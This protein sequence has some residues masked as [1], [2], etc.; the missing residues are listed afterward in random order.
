ML[1]FKVFRYQDYIHFIFPST[2]NRIEGMITY[3]NHL[4]VYKIE[5]WNP[6]N[7]FRTLTYDRFYIMIDIPFISSY[8]N[9]YSLEENDIIDYHKVEWLSND[10]KTFLDNITIEL[11]NNLKDRIEALRAYF[12]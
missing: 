8:K 1:D 10:V 7:K 2:E 9:E 11:Q 5:I 3:D 12:G 6:N 4:E